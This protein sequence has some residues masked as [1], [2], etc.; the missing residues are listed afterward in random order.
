MVI[1]GNASS[2]LET[3]VNACVAQREASYNP[4]EPRS[5]RTVL[6]ASTRRSIREVAPRT[7]QVSDSLRLPNRTRLLKAVSSLLLA[8][9]IGAG[10]PAAPLQKPNILWVVTDDQR[11]DSLGCYNRATT[12][13]SRSALGYV[14]SPHVDR[15]ASQG[16]LFT[17]AY[18][19][20]MACA[21]SRAS[22]ITG[23]YPHHNGIY[24]FE[25]SHRSAGCASRMIPEVL[26]EHGYQPASFGKSGVRIFPYESMRQ[27]RPPGFY[28]PIIRPKD[29]EPTEFS[30]FWF[31]RPW[32][33]HDGKGMVLG[34][35]EVFRY[36][37][38]VER[39]FWLNRVDRE[40]TPDE[41][42]TRRSVEQDLNILRSY[43]RRNGD[44]IIG[45]VSPATTDATLD[46][47]I[48]RCLEEYLAN[49]SAAYRSIAGKEY[50][51]PDP[52]RPLFTYVGF[53]FPH[54]PVLPSKEFRDRFAREE[55]SPP[56]FDESGVDRLPPSLRRLR[57][58]MDFSRMSDAEKQQ[59]IQDYYAF[60][61]MG[62][63]LVGRAVDSFTNY[64]KSHDQD[65]VIVFV[66]GDHGWHLGEQGIEA[67]FAPWFQTVHDCIV[68][69]SSDEKRYQPGT[70]C[71]EMVEFVDL[72]P[73][74][75]E[76]AGVPLSD[77]PGL[78]GVSLAKTLSEGRQRD[79]ILGEMNQVCGDWAYLRS[80]EFN[81]AMR[82]RP[83]FSKPGNGF[84]PGE[85]MR[86]AIEA[87]VDAIEMVLY[88]LRIDAQETTNVAADEAYRPLAAFLRDKLTSIVL[89]DRRVE[90]DW[91]QENAYHLSEF[92]LG[93]H[94][95]RLVIPPNLAPAVLPQGR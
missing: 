70:V 36:P 71:S 56:D 30:D 66:C 3:F 50:A 82:V 60:C 90:C 73:T 41:L 17:N 26:K 5:V 46:G 18:C 88:D 89:G 54:T 49:P 59:A 53:H 16:V 81:F 20:S 91:S 25:Q 34:T 44:L 42:A 29:L 23:K 55:Y 83:F 92:A 45:G 76:A 10:L 39:R 63:R 6:H 8:T 19:N 47:A 35:E 33:R 77:H 31:N 94:D 85:R 22:M 68:V 14:E 61:A 12:G 84:A 11:S 43:T 87:P 1:R 24:G 57:E 32:G 9:S 95:R 74:F 75:Y 64:C 52:T 72:A 69:V 7:G 65:Y 58:Q 27:W 40:I 79:Y 48:V 86:W 4:M 93:S 78:D 38:G 2:L 13:E 67:K 37:G 15:L 51:G 80:D 21:P 62:D 28:N